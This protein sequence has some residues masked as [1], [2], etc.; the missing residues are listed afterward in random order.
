[1]ARWSGCGR[2]Q[3]THQSLVPRCVSRG[4]CWRNFDQ[5]MQHPLAVLDRRRQMT[6]ANDCRRKQPQW[7]QQ[8]PAPIKHAVRV[9]GDEWCWRKREPL[10]EM[11]ALALLAVEC[12]AAEREPAAQTGTSGR[13]CSGRRLLLDS[14][15]VM[16]GTGDIVIAD[17]GGYRQNVIIR[18]RGAT[19]WEPPPG[20]QWC[21]SRNAMA[22]VR[23]ESSGAAPSLI[24]TAPRAMLARRLVVVHLQRPDHRSAVCSRGSGRPA[25]RFKRPSW[26]CH[27]DFFA[28]SALNKVLPRRRDS[29]R[30]RIAQCVYRFHAV[31]LSASDMLSAVCQLP[32]VAY[33]GNIHP[34][35]CFQHVR[36]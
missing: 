20:V 3:E 9:A 24:T 18:W 19:P 17:A 12:P 8:R 4:R 28:H 36:G 35:P 23:P 6:S 29:I 30:F 13:R 11:L 14:G 27:V 33:R 34:I 7:R 2:G 10:R 21:W 26:S 5:V 32:S 1:M 15:V 16:M 25:A 22:E 31:A